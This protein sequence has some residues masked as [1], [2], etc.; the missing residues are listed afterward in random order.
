MHQQWLYNYLVGK[1]LGPGFDSRQLHRTNGQRKNYSISWAVP[2]RMGNIKTVV[3][4]QFPAVHQAFK[5][6]PQ[7]LE[8]LSLTEGDKTT[9]TKYGQ[10][11]KRARFFRTKYL[12]IG[13]LLSGHDNQTE[14][15]GSLLFKIKVGLSTYDEQQTY[16][17]SALRVLLF[18]THTKLRVVIRDQTV[19]YVQYNWPVSRYFEHWTTGQCGY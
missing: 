6:V 19:A 16:Y 3:W 10:P 18:C 7:T 14:C 2:C 9:D 4:V 17:Q 11:G 15:M 5:V 8:R 1:Y 12:C 13:N